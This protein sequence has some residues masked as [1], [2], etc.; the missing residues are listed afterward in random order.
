MTDRLRKTNVSIRNI[1]IVLLIVSMFYGQGSSQ[2]VLAQTAEP[3]P[4]RAPGISYPLES[5]SSASSNL[6]WSANA[7]GD[8]SIQAGLLS[9]ITDIRLDGLV[10][11]VSGNEMKMRNLRAK[12]DSTELTDYLEV[13]YTCG[14]HR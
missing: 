4:V 3:V 14:W 11:T 13:T 2:K 9:N 6:L 10:M 5:D 12:S 1:F 8:F 7:M